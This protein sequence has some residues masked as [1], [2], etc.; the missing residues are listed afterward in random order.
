M[1]SDKTIK[2]LVE[3]ARRTL[4]H[5]AGDDEPQDLHE[6]QVLTKRFTEILNGRK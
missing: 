3:C 5:D 6:I 4:N 2:A 1:A